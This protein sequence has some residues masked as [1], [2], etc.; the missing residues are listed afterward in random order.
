MLNVLVFTNRIKVPIKD[1]FDKAVEY[2][3]EMTDG[4]VNISFTFQETDFTGFSH[5]PT[6]NGYN[7]ILGVEDKLKPL[8]KNEPIVIFAFDGSEFPV[9]MTSNMAGWVKPHV[10]LINLTTT[11]AHDEVGWIWKS[12]THELMHAFFQK[13][14]FAGLTLTDPM[15]EMLVNGVPTKYFLNHDPYSKEGNYAEALKQLAPHW[16]KIIPQST[17]E[18]P[19]ATL[20]RLPGNHPQTVGHLV[21]KKGNETFD[22]RTIER[23]WKNNQKNI[24]AIPKGTY[25]CKWTFSTKFMRYTYE[26]LNVPNRSGIRIHSGSYWFDIQGCILLGTH[27]ADFN[28]DGIADLVNS[29]TTVKSF[30]SFLDKKDFTLII[31]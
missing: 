21:V 28:K 6:E 27:Y 5:E 1:D 17:P 22:C 20:T 2:F 10:T 15:D 19:V 11:K 30:E 13:A 31:K 9:N 14:F 23:E 18:K 12:I 29:R 24:S 8:V 16:D 25:T 3:K 7:R 4:K 26:V